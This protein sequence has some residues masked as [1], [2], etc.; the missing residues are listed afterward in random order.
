LGPEVEVETI[1]LHLRLGHLEEQQIGGHT[2]GRTAH[3]W[4]RDHL[5][6][7]HEG[8][9]PPERRLPEC[10]QGQ[11]IVGVDGQGLSITSA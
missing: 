8:D 5:V 6:G 7:L 3:R 9:P 11:R 1:L 4:F 2:V 10:G